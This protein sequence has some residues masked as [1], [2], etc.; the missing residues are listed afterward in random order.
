MIQGSDVSLRGRYSLITPLRPGLT[1]LDHRC[2]G[3]ELA[4]RLA[5]VIG[6]A[7]IEG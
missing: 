7:L 1:L 3:L 4:Y 6:S 5:V 2:A